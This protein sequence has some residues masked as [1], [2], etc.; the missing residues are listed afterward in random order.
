MP[1]PYVCAE[2]GH[3]RDYDFEP[4]LCADCGSWLTMKEVTPDGAC[5]LNR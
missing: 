1:T 2:C 3:T 5:R 4:D